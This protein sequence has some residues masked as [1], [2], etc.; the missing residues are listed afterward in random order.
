MIEFDEQGVLRFKA[1]RIVRDVHDKHYNLN[2]IEREYQEGRYTLAEKY[3]YL[4]L[5]GYSID[6]W[7]SLLY[8]DKNVVEKEE[9]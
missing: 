2:Q 6:G 3:E 1:N 8:Q 7:E 4:A 9:G 5:I